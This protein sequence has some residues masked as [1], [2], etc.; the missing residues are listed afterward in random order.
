MFV[1][2]YSQIVYQINLSA[3][4]FVY[5]DTRANAFY[6]MMILLTTANFPD[7]MLPSYEENW[8]TCFFFIGFLCI[9][10]YFL[11]SILLAN[12]YTKFQ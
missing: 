7:I 8:L 9:V 1:L 3:S 10:L 5:F 4:S 6:H 11:L 2:V 12:V